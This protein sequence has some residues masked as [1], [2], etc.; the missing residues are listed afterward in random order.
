MSAWVILLT[1]ASPG[2]PRIDDLASEDRLLEA[3][4]CIPLFWYML[5]DRAA[6]IRAEEV[7]DDEEDGPYTYAYAALSKPT[8]EALALAR[9]R[10][11]GVR[12]VL[13][14]GTDGLFARWAGFVE[15]NARAYLHC[16]TFELAFLHSDPSFESEVKTCI[17][18]FDH[19]PRRR[20]GRPAL[21]R[22]WRALLGQCASCDREDRIRPLGDFSYCGY[23]WTREV[24][25]SIEMDD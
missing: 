21:N 8:A 7:E 10:W 6:I 12:E 15:A 17:D 20:E 1:T 2:K 23:S 14:P 3:R 25:R 4:T 5:F 18:A 11:P 9:S 24:P 22:W 13:G 16:E 19:I